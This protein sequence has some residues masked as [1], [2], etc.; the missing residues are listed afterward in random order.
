MKGVISTVD[1]LLAAQLK[2]QQQVPEVHAARRQ[3]Q[4]Q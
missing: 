4:M 2:M 3:Q 1:K